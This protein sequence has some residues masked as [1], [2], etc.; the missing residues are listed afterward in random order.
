MYSFLVLNSDKIKIWNLLKK[1]G[2]TYEEVGNI[3]NLPEED[4]K[5]QFKKHLS[6]DELI[7]TILLLASKKKEGENFHRKRNMRL[8]L[9]RGKL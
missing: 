2:R 1:E 4:I 3:L 5:K 6:R 7:V 9:S 8:Q